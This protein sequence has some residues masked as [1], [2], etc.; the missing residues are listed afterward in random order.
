MAD[1]LPCFC[2][3]HRETEAIN[4][5]IK[6]CFKDGQKVFT[7]L[8]L[9]F[10]C[11]FEVAFELL[12]KNAVI[13][14][15]FLLFTKLAAVLGSL[16]PALAMLAGSICSAR[17]GALICIASV[18]FQEELLALSAAKAADSICISCH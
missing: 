4:N 5:V 18:T 17:E 12:F 6:S 1:E 15:G 2:A 11:H 9:S 16:A 10:A 7:C 8:A 3:A 14:L 13:S